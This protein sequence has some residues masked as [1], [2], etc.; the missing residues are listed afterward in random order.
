MEIKKST[1][2]YLC[3]PSGI[4]TGGPMCMH[5]LGFFLKETLRLNVYMFYVP[6]KKKYKYLKNPIH[7]NFR[8]LNLEFVDKIEDVED[9][10][11]ISPEDFFFSKS[12]K[13]IY[14]N[15]K[16]DLVA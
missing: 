9:N 16:N 8:H 1:K 12:H 2:I 4:F 5:Q 7:E 10:I 3:S 11:I 15:T 13:K 6:V 14:Q